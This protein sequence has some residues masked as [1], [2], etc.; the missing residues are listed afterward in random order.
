[1]RNLIFFFFFVTGYLFSQNPCPGL[2]T[3]EY[4]GKTYNTVQIGEQ[5]WL[6]ENLDIGTMIDSLQNEYA[7]P[8]LLMYQLKLFECDHIH[9]LRYLYY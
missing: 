1:M 6:K 8:L 3:V 7:F 5:C 4:E 9:E 2:E